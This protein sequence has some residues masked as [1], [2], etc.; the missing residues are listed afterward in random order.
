MNNMIGLKSNNPDKYVV[1]NINDNI[2]CVHDNNSGNN[3]FSNKMIAKCTGLGERSVEIHWRNF[4][5]LNSNRK[6]L[7][8]S[9]KV[10]NSDKPVE[11]KSFDFLTYVTYRSNKSEA[12]LMRNY[13]VDALDDKFNK[14]AGFNQSKS[15]EQEAM[16]TI[17]YLEKKVWEETKN[18]FESQTKEDFIRHMDLADKYAMD[19]QK[20]RFQLRNELNCKKRLKRECELN[21]KGF[22]TESCDLQV[23]LPDNQSTLIEF[24]I[25]QE[26]EKE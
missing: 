2:C 15:L 26:V 21:L 8:V 22:L 24:K 9:L 25:I 11:F 12:I 3:Y 20:R 14:D 18:A 10:L 7:S 19:S 4:K 23:F 17:H 5:E 16:E 6:N 1:V 13:I